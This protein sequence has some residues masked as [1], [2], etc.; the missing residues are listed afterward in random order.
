LLLQ[1][2]IENAILHGLINKDGDR[3]LRILFR[4]QDDTMLC[5][6]ED[7]GIGRE[8]SALIRKAKGND[9][10]SKGIEISTNRL[11]LMYDDAN[12]DELIKIIDL[13]NDCRESV[14]TRVEIRIPFE[15]I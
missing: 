14:G 4:K 1:I 15:T 12:F 8:A 11:R 6:I 3:H 10:Q 9:H 2:H 13:Y 7:N 5:V